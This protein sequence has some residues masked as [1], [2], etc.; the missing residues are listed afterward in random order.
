[1]GTELC[2]L[3]SSTVGTRIETDAFSDL[4]LKPFLD[5]VLVVEALESDILCGQSTV[6]TRDLVGARPKGSSSSERR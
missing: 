1:M 6:P 4:C 3:R 2:S 5:Q